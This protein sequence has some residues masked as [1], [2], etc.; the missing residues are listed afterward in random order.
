MKGLQNFI[1]TH[2][3]GCLIGGGTFLAILLIFFI[4]FFIMPAFSNNRYGDRL[5]GIEKHK[6]QNS[7]IN[8]IKE[9]IQNEN[10]VTKVSYKNEGRIIRFIITTDGSVD[11]ETAKGYTRFITDT[12]SKKNQSYYDIEVI[13][14]SKEAKEGF[15]NAGYKHKTSKEF[16]WGNVGESSE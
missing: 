14:N 3:K 1:Q 11:Y 13:L 2:K 9:N 15:P 7:Q 10:G 4:I 12:I 5:D 8:E 6:I 16:S